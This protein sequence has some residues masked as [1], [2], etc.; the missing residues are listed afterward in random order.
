ML[1][2][3]NHTLPHTLCRTSPSFPGSFG[4]FHLAK[5]AI[6]L[7]L[8]LLPVSLLQCFTLC[9]LCLVLVSSLAHDGVFVALGVFMDNLKLVQ[10]SGF[11]KDKRHNCTGLVLKLEK[12][13][14]N[15]QEPLLSLQP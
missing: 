6:Q 4:L 11:L 7:T 5:H 15:G 8:C 12:E 3:I 14:L 1:V 10:Q 2:K 9:E 13:K